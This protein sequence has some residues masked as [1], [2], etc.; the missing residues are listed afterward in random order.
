[1]RISRYGILYLSISRLFYFVAILF[2]FIFV[3]NLNAENHRLD[4]PHAF[5]TYGKCVLHLIANFA[6]QIADNYIIM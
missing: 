4:R 5:R 2:R 1:M 6:F 3:R